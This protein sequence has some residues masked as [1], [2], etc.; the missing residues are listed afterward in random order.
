LSTH[1]EQQG[2][3]EKEVKTSGQVRINQVKKEVV[4]LAKILQTE[5]VLVGKHKPKPEA[6]ISKIK[7]RFHLHCTFF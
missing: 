3:R 6:K 1:G 4:V 7:V 2:L 5:G